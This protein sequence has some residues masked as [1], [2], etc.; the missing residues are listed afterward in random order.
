[1]STLCV[2]PPPNSPP[3][4]AKRAAMTMIRKI[5]RIATTPV[6][7][8]LSLSAM[9]SNPPSLTRAPDR[10]AANSEHPK[11]PRIT[12]RAARRRPRLITVREQTPLPLLM[13]KA[14]HKI[15]LEVEKLKV[16]RRG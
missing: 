15:E 4:Q 8:E 5:T 7:L 14:C 12:K 16:K 9:Y 11:S 2:P 6:L 3:R 10:G 13:K 1:M